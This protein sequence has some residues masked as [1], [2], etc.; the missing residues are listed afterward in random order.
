MELCHNQALLIKKWSILVPEPWF[1]RI[2]SRSAGVFIFNIK[3]PGLIILTIQTSGDPWGGSTLARTKIKWSTSLWYTSNIV[4]PTVF[5]K[6]FLQVQG[7]ILI[8]RSV[9]VTQQTSKLQ[10]LGCYVYCYI[11]YH[12]PES[13]L[14]EVKN[15]KMF[16]V[17]FLLCNT[18]QVHDS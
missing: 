8:Q 13:I 1:E 17:H 18:K 9:F 6:I 15:L 11:I 16:P 2:W 12:F 7:S 14:A 10:A 4:G 3:A 5:Q